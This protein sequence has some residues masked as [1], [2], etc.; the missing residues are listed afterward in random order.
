MAPGLQTEL[1]TLGILVVVIARFL[2]RELRARTVRVST[3]WMRPAF[4]GAMTVLVIW[5]TLQSPQAS[6]VPILPWLIGGTAIGMVVGY[7]VALST[8]VESTGQA[9]VVRLRGS[10]VTVGIWV[11]AVALRFLVRLAFGGTIFST[12][13]AVNGGTVILVAAAFTVFAVLIAQRV[14]ELGIVRGAST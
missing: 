2:L 6:G 11:A 13:P 14:R 12:S 5:A 7:F 10:W 8:R 9:G 1:I 3:L 4:L